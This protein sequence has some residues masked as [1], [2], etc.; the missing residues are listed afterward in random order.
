MVCWTSADPTLAPRT[1]LLVKHTT[2][3]V[4]AVVTSLHYRMDVNTLHRDE[5]AVRLG[6]NEIGRVRLR[7][8][9]PLFADPYARN[10]ATGGFILIDEA[11]SATLG[12][13]MIIEVR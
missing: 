4:K 12:A 5:S 10:R 7:L 13:A 1:R 8:T 2:K 9:Q 3:T 6:I 11:T